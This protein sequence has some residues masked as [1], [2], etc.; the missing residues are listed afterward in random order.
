VENHNQLQG[1]LGFPIDISILLKYL[2]VLK[3]THT[4]NHARSLP[5]VILQKFFNRECM[6]VIM[7]SN[8]F[9]FITKTPLMMMY[10]SENGQN[11]FWNLFE[12]ISILLTIH[13]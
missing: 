2:V 4:C 5:F 10:L 6:H 11:F 3:K 1:C 8:G 13:L 9:S 7:H 12:G